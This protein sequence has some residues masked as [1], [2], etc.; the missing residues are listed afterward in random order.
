MDAEDEGDQRDRR[1]RHPRQT[2]LDLPPLLHP[3]GHRTGDA[4][5]V[6]VGE[7]DVFLREARGQLL[8]VVEVGAGSEEGT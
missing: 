1:Q 3:R 6:V 8:L 7:A 5:Q 4:D 2:L